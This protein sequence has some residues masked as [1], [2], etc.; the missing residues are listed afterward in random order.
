MTNSKRPPPWSGWIFV[1]LLILV[2][3][4]Y[5]SIQARVQRAELMREQAEIKALVWLAAERSG[6]P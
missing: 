1:T 5:W 6:S 3:Q 2:W 4:G